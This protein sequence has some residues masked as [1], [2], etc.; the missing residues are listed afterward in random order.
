MKRLSLVAIIILM[1]VSSC[2]LGAPSIIYTNVPLSID[3]KIIPE[4]GTVNQPLYI[5][6]HCT[7][8]DGCWKNLY[9]SFHKLQ[10]FNYELVALGDYESYGACPDITVVADT[11][12]SFTPETAGE[13]I[14]LTWLTP[15]TNTKDTIEVVTGA[16][17]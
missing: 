16:G 1:T 14:I 11:T 15:T 12:I 8:P 5:S 10:D 4:T 6:A 3:G 9:F 17:R 7:A 2:K 13:Y